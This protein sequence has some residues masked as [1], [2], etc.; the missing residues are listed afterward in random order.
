MSQQTVKHKAS[1]FPALISAGLHRFL[2]LLVCFLF[3]SIPVI[4]QEDDYEDPGEDINKNYK[5]GIKIGMSGSILKAKGDDSVETSGVRT[6]FTTG[7]YGRGKLSNK[8]SLQF[9][10][11]GTY[12]G[13]E[14]NRV[15][16]KK[17]NDIY[18][19]MSLF[20]VDF[21]IELQYRVTKEKPTILV[22]GFQPSLLGASSIGT[23]QD[24]LRLYRQTDLPIH[25][26]DYSVIGGVFFQWQALGIQI[27][28]KSG[29]TNI[30]Q[31]FTDPKTGVVYEKF[32]NLRPSLAHIKE[33][34]NF[35]IEAAVIF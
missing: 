23:Y 31:G 4:A 9:G 26:M 22:V 20:Y 3:I 25:P 34:K 5:L 29:L 17:H 6:G 32:K 12:R 10:V 27:M 14:F 7:I 30:S 19:R 1:R 11:Y 2:L 24:E 8:F 13:G 33:L 15:E 18:R 21:P 16:S 28:A 35:S